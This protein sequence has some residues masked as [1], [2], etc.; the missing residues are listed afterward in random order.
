MDNRITDL[1]D[2]DFLS[3]L[4]AERDREESLNSRCQRDARGTGQW[5]HLKL[6]NE[7]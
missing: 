6:M 5:H 3:F 2:S 1:S 4:Y 7:V